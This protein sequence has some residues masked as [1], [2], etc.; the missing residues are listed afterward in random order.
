MKATVQIH[1]HHHSGPDTSG[2]CRTHLGNVL[3]AA[4]RSL[5]LV[6]LERLLECRRV[7]H[8]DLYLIGKRAAGYGGGRAGWG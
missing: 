7:V 4:Q 3:P 8:D 2:S 1:M 6:F 5:A